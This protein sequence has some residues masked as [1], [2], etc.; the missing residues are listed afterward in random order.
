MNPGSANDDI[1]YQLFEGVGIGGTL[2]ASS[3]FILEGSFSGFYLADFSAVSLAIGN[4][5]SLVASIV[6]SSP[7][8]GV[9][10]TSSAAAMAGIRYGESGDYYS[11]ALT[12]APTSVPEPGTLA[13]F[14]LGLAAMG[15]SRRRKKI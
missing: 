6:G 10:S 8:W 13:L 12:V 11:F 4:T 1:L 9:N 14:G 3:Q 15:L 5:Y 2:L 7:L